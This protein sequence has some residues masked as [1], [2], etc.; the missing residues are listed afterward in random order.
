[1][2]IVRGFAGPDDLEI[3]LDAARVVAG[4]E[5]EDG[6]GAMHGLVA[7]DVAGLVVA[8]DELAKTIV[9]VD[10]LALLVEHCAQRRRRVDQGR[11]QPAL[12]GQSR[13][14]FVAGTEAQDLGGDE[15][16]HGAQQRRQG[17]DE[18]NTLPPLAEKGLDA[19]RHADQHGKAFDLTRGDDASFRPRRLPPLRLSRDLRGAGKALANHADRLGVG[20]GLAQ[21]IGHVQRCREQRAVE[22]EQR[23]RAVLAE[24]D[25]A[26]QVG[27]VVRIR[28]RR[29]RRP[30]IRRLS[31]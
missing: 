19:D 6:G 7:Q 27:K 10:H 13:R 17:E 12:R 5:G 8:S 26:K 11:Q 31:T 16:R 14:R 1:M 20:V 29:R 9:A 23:Y 24:R 4:G 25:Q 30:A 22:P 21:Q 15:N 18:I 3:D 28:C 2:E